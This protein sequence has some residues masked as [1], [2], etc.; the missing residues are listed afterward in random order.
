[1]ALGT[2]VLCINFPFI[3][4]WLLCGHASVSVPIIYPYCE[5]SDN[6]GTLRGTRG[7]CLVEPVGRLSASAKFHHLANSNGTN[8]KLASYPAKGISE[9]WPGTESTPGSCYYWRLSFI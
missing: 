9:A 6:I 5:T 7:T 4:F 1:M 3:F 2:Q 8:G